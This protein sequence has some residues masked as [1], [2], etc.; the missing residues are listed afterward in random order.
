MVN[1]NVTKATLVPDILGAR[2]AV[3]PLKKLLSNAVIRQA[4]Y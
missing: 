3:N 2:E 4:A 1:L